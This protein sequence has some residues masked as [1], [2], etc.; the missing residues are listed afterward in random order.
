LEHHLWALDSGNAIGVDA[1]NSIEVC[2]R[3]RAISTIHPH[4][5]VGGNRGMSTHESEEVLTLL[6]ELSMLKELDSQFESGAKTESECAAHR[7]RQK[8][9]REIGEELKALAQQK[10]RDAE[11]SPSSE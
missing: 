5:E 11:P 8:R 4:Q 1:Q 10:K 2:C 7:L 3:L 6:K 9:H